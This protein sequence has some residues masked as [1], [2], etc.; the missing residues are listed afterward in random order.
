MRVGLCLPAQDHSHSWFSYDLAGMVGHTVKERSDI[1]LRRFQATGTW[2]PQV[3]HRTVVAALNAQCDWLLFLDNDMR[4]PADTLVKLLDRGKTVVA[5]NY[6]ARH[7]P[8]CPVAVN[9]NAERVY[10]EYESTGLEE[11]AS[12]GM[13]VMLVRSD[14]LRKIAP[15]WFMLG[16]DD[17]IQDYKGEDSYFCRKLRETGAQIWL[18]HDLSHDVTHL[19]IIEFEQSHAVKARHALTETT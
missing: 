16:W 5:A 19:G 6:T 11:I 10:T 14:L 9:G 3:R 1:E 18:D 7:V 2:L 17:A 8:F 13:G 15:P 4:F 12:V